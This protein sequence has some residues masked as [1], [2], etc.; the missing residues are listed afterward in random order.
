MITYSSKR[1]TVILMVG[2]IGTAITHNIYYIGFLLQVFI[3]TAYIGAFEVIQYNREL[4]KTGFLKFLGVF[5]LII[6]S[7]A[8]MSYLLQTLI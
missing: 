4:Y 1:G 7:I 5:G 2:V 3:I 8:F 6:W